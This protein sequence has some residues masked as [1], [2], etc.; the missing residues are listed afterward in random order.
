MAGDYF[1]G[2]LTI[3]LLT[4]GLCMEQTKSFHPHEFFGPFY[5]YSSLLTMG[6]LAS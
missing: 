1:P 5:I 6:E 3:F 4:T 2:S